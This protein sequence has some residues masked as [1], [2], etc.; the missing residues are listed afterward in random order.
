MVDRERVLAKLDELESYL[1]ELRQVAPPTFDAY[2]RSLE[3]RRACERLLQIAV[4]AVIDVCALLVKGLRLG[5]PGE[6]DDVFEKLQQAGVLSEAMVQTLRRMRRFRN[7]LVHEYGQIDDRLVFE[8]LQTHL[9]DF[10][11]FRDEVVQALKRWTAT[12]E[13]SRRKANG[14]DNAND[15]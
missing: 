10:E 5:L 3:K 8:I 11:A 13:E 7:L 4:E 6:E 12:A 2:Q 1:R 15:K 14:G 9:G